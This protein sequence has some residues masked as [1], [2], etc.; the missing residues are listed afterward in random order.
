VSVGLMLTPVFHRFLHRFH[1]E[2]EDES[3]KSR[4]RR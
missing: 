4:R 2:E 3:E 1:I